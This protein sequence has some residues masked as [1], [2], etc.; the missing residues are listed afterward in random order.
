[1]KKNQAESKVCPFIQ[2]GETPFKDPNK[3]TYP[4]NINCVGNSC[5]AW[6]NT[7]ENGTAIDGSMGFGYCKLIDKK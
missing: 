4:A 3:R 7:D 1:M 2:I 6:Q 5:M